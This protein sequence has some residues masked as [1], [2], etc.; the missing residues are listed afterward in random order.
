MLV[1]LKKRGPIPHEGIGAYAPLANGVT[2]RPSFLA[3]GGRVIEVE[4]EANHSF[5]C[6]FK[7]I[8][9][10]TDSRLSS[11]C[12][13]PSYICPHYL[14]DDLDAYETD[15]LDDV[16]PVLITEAVSK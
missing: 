15:A 10:V 14:I 13:T 4:P 1:R 12:A 9:R 11:Y 2:T 8:Y 3:W 16:D 5:W 6:E 7:T